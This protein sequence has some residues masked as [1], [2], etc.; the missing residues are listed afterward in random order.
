MES[1]FQFLTTV[2]PI[3]VITLLGLIIFILV[4]GKKLEEGQNEITT[5]H[6]HGLP[7]MA[8]TLKRIEE[9]LDRNFE[10][11]NADISYIKARLNGRRT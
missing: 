9:K 11:Q 6:L 7:E 1:L 10:K 2:Q 8:D 5:N 4:K 3:G